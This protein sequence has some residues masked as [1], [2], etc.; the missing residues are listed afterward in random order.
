MLKFMIWKEFLQLRRDKK[1]FFILFLA[2]V[3]QLIVLGFAA[4]F[5]VQQI[6][7]AVYDSDNTKESR[8]YT[9]HYF[10]G[11]YFQFTHNLSSMKQ[12]DKLLESGEIDTAIVIKKG[13]QKNILS[14]K[15]GEVSIII[16]GSDINSATQTLSYASRITAKYNLNKIKEKNIIV[17]ETPGI[18]LSQRILYNP[19]LKTRNFMVPAIM[20]IILMIITTMLTSMAIVREKEIGTI[21]QLIVT[22]IDKKTILAG[23]IIPFMIIGFLDIA[24]I[25]VVTVYLFKVPLKGDIFLLA[26]SAGL[27]LFNTLGLGLFVSTISSTQQQAMMAVIFFIIMPFIYLSGFV[28]PIENMPETFQY[29]AN[30]IP[31]TH[32]LVLIRGIFLKGSGFSELWFNLTALLI[33]GAVIFAISVKRFKKSV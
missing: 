21:E 26:L 24:V 15:S 1:M 8:N 31:L 25:S 6:K 33:T 2:P 27:F 16:N 11:K 12:A 13:F 32:F 20:G 5:D 18:T 9:S 10:S 29:I 7:T 19:Q 4:N 30:V 22:P 23:K 14:G 28:F 3:I 17:H